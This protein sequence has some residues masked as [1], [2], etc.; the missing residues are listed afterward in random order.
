MSISRRKFVSIGAGCAGFAL[1]GT[2]VQADDELKPVALDDPQVKALGYVH[3]TENADT[4]KFANHDIA[5]NCANCRLIQAKEG[6]WRPCAIFPGKAV[7][8]SGWCS[9]WVAKA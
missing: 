6:E 2:N 5:Q 4:A 1:L 9:A 7:N 8:E 3:N